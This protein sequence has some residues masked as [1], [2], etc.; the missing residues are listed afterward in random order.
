MSEGKPGKSGEPKEGSGSPKPSNSD[1]QQYG[2]GNGNPLSEEESGKLFEIYKQQQELKQQLQE[3]IKTSGLPSDSNHLIRKMESIENQLLERGFDD[4]I[5][6][7]MNNLKHDLLKLDKAVFEHGEDNKR[8]SQSNSVEFSTSPTKA[9]PSIEQY[10]NEIEILN[11][12]AL[13]LQPIYKKKVKQYF[14]KTHD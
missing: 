8:E 13:P 7:Q 6:K 10:F 5:L 3:L 4:S 14:K 2:E 9:L 11:R 1:G 12:Q